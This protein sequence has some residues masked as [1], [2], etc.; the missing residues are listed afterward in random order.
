MSQAET[1]AVPRKTLRRTKTSGA[2]FAHYFDSK[3][4]GDK[5]GTNGD[6]LLWGLKRYLVSAVSA[7]ALT[8][9]RALMNQPC[10]LMNQPVPL[11]TNLPR[12]KSSRELGRFCALFG[13]KES[14]AGWNLPFFRSEIG[15]ERLE[16]AFDRK[17][18][19]LEAQAA[20]LTSDTKKRTFRSWPF[21]ALFAL[22]TE[23]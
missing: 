1:S 2:A 22:T 3:A 6:K 15:S 20:H 7:A 8:C 14:G 10:P 12:T 17:R 5:A 23:R 9:G 13:P 4:S 16:P 19:K 21:C 18:A 11:L